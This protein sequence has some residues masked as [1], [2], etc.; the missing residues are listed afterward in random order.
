MKNFKTRCVQVNISIPKAWKEELENI[1]R[2][3][4]VE[5]GRTVTFLELMRM[6]LKEKFQLSDVE[7]EA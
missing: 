2:V 3:Y 6:G 7:D 4:S 1:A 5:E